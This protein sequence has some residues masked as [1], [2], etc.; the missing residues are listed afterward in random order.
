MQELKSVEKNWY[1]DW[2]NPEHG[3]R[4]DAR[5]HLS[6]RDLARNYEAYNDIRLLNERIDGESSATLVEV[7][8]ATGELYRYLRGRHPRLRYIGIDI[9]ENAVLRAKEKYVQAAFCVGRPGETVIEILKRHGIFEKPDI[10][11]SKDVVHHQTDSYGF[12]NGLLDTPRSMAILRLRTRD[13]GASELDP[14]RSCQ[15]HYDQWVPFIVLNLDEVIAR[16]QQRFAQC[17]IVVRRNYT[18]L[19]GENGRFLPRECYLK[20]TGTSQTTLGVFLKTD[21]PGRVTVEDRK[22][23]RPRYTLGLRLKRLARETVRTFTD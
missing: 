4:F 8:C 2:Q 15:Y 1:Q 11:Y 10:I 17:E 18:V 12:L 21:A 13:V 23:G 3:V 9:S 19:G 16:V 5:A 20:E 14:E 6:A 22:D 7:G